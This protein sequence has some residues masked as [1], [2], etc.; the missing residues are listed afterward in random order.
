[1]VTVRNVAPSFQDGINFRTFYQA[2]RGWLIS[3]CPLRD[4]ASAGRDFVNRSAGR[5][6]WLGKLE[7]TCECR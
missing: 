2:L 4:D 6:G 3:G 1:M 7:R 5:T